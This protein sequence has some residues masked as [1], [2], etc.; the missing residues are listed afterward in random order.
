MQTLKSDFYRIYMFRTM[1]RVS[2]KIVHKLFL[3]RGTFDN[4]QANVRVKWEALG[5]PNTEVRCR[6]STLQTSV[7]RKKQVCK[8]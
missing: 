8:R 6:T 5:H 2:T 3:T 1:R 7:K 4:I